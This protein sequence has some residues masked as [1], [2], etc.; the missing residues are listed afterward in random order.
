MS[1][2]RIGGRSYQLTNA[3]LAALFVPADTQRVKK[4]PGVPGLEVTKHLE[5]EL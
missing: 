2:A 1:V 3:T 5:G 4:A